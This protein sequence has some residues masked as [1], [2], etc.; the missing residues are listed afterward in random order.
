MTIESKES[1]KEDK[2]LSGDSGQ[3]QTPEYSVYIYHQAFD[4]LPQKW[5]KKHSTAYVDQAIKRAKILY[6]SDKYSKVEVKKI[7]Q[8]RDED[9]AVEKC[10]KVYKVSAFE[11]YFMRMNRLL[12][13]SFAALGLMA[14]G[15]FFYLLV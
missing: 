11:T 1:S 2:D 9:R 8:N 6:K 13:F 4:G 7:E 5:E 10:C 15:V 14:C 3:G 12:I